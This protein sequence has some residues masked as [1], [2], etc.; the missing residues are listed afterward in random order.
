VPGMLGGRRSL[1]SVSRL[2]SIVDRTY[3]VFNARDFDAYGELLDENVE[4]SCR[5]WWCAAWRP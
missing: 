1:S 3:E 2:S 5:G 4:R